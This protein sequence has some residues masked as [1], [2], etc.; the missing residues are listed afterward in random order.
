MGS[1]QRNKGK[2]GER[3]CAAII[4]QHWNATEAR[5]SVQFCG[6]AGDADLVGV[7]G[8]HLEVKRYAGIA[9]CRFGEQAQRDATPGT[10]PVV[11]MREDGKTQWWAML[12]V[13]DCPAFARALLGVLGEK[14]APPADDP[15][16]GLE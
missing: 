14:A 4:S 13:E 10:V 3:E 15:S 1:H 12:P 6:R 2:R 8:V 7:P 16:E 11:L 9:A 5:R